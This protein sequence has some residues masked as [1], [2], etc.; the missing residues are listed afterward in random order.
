LPLPLPLLFFVILLST[1]RWFIAFSECL[2]SCSCSNV[3]LSLT[4]L[5]LSALPFYDFCFRSRALCYI[6]HAR[7]NV[8]GWQ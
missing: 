2:N 3:L 4:A 6:L 1:F 5:H 7:Y 8:I